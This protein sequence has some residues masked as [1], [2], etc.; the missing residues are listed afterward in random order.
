MKG[1]NGQKLDTD[2]GT[3][4]QSIDQEDVTDHQV[5]QVQR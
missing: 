3:D 2:Q 4:Q 5:D 1:H